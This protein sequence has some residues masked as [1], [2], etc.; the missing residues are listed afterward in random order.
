MV[1]DMRHVM[2]MLALAMLVPVMALANHPDES[3]VDM[4]AST[5]ACEVHENLAKGSRGDEV[6]CLQRA[7]IGAGL[8]RIAAPTGYFGEFTEAAVREWQMAYGVASTGFFGP[9]SRTAFG[10]HAEAVVTHAVA[11]DDAAVHAHEALDVGVWPSMPSVA[12]TLHADALSG[13][14]LEIT[15]QNFTFAPQHVNGAVVPNE[16]H[17][18]VMVNGVKFARVYD[19]WFHIPGETFREGENEVLVTLNANDH[20]EL[21]HNGARIEASQHV[22]VQ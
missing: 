9:H 11:A 18:H 5:E 2:G 1:I 12:V 17:A 20:S 3:Y 7:L 19:T 15:P 14:N 10:G 4:H 6:I 22:V 13:Y 16:G 21:E 8:L